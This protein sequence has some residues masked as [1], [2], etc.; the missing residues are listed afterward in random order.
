MLFKIPCALK[1]WKI[2]FRPK[3]AYRA[4]DQYLL[5]ARKEVLV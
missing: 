4:I 2:K 1:G 3:Y 5:P